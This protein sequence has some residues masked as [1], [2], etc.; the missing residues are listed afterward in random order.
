MGESSVIVPSLD[1][2]VISQ[3]SLASPFIETSAARAVEA[4]MPSIIAERRWN[5]K[6][7]IPVI[8]KAFRFLKLQHHR[9]AE[10]DIDFTRCPIQDA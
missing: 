1:I 9:V 5:L 2:P 6:L 7:C 3:E 10:V 4:A 8:Q